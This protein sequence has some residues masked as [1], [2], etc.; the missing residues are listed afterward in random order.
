MLQYLF[1]YLIHVLAKA[2]DIGALLRNLVNYSL[3]GAME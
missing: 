1:S 3:D 2:D